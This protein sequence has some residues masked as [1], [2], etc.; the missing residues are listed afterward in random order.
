MRL[1]RYVCVGGGHCCR[2]LDSGRLGKF[3]APEPCSLPHAITLP[4]LLAEQQLGVQLHCI[5]DIASAWCTH[6]EPCDLHLL[7]NHD[8]ECTYGAVKSY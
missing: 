2:C 8:E 6:K 4:P 5:I 3:Q 1:E 7:L